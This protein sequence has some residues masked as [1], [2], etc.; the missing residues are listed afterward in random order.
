MTARDAV[1]G[2]VLDARAVWAPR[3]F[4]AAL[5]LLVLGSLLVVLGVLA[6]GALMPGIVVLDVAMLLLAAAGILSA[7]TPDA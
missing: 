7:M 5:T 4:F 3:I 1:A 2:R 6:P